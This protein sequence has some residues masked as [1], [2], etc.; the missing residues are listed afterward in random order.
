MDG[1][2][3]SSL[4]IAGLVALILFII[5]I[6]IMLVSVALG[7]N[8]KYFGSRFLNILFYTSTIIY[9]ISG[10]TAIMLSLAYEL[11]K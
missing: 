3:M 4:E 2:K 8:A 11:M 10:I 7:L 6:V 9:G 1:G 5:G